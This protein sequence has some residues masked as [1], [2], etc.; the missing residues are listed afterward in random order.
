MSQGAQLMGTEDPDLL[1]QEYRLH[2]KTIGDEEYKKQSALLLSSRDRF[3][4]ARINSTL[5][6]GEVGLLFLGMAHAVEPLLDTDILARHLLPALREKQ[7]KIQC[8]A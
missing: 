6:A 1:L 5:M 4:A 7:E 8:K 3:I 2:Q